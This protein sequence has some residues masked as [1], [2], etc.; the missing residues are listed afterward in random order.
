MQITL[1]NTLSNKREVFKPLDDSRVT[2]YVC[3][4]TVYG[5]AHLGNA[6]PAVVFDILF[7]L[8]SR[9]YPKVE[10]ARNITD[11]D[12]KIITAAAENKEP[13]A[14]LTE[15]WRARYE[16]E[17]N[18][19]GVLPPTHAPLATQYINEIITL[20][21]KLIAKGNAYA[22]HGHVFF[23]TP[24]FADY[25]ALSNRKGDAPAVARV[26]AQPFKQDPTDFVLWKPST[27]EMPGWQSPWGRGR[28]G[29]HIECSAMAAAC[30]GETI[31]IHGGGQDLIFPH[32]ENEIAQSRCAS[33]EKVFANYWLH[34]G[35]LALAG[36][37]M[38]KSLG[39]DLS[40]GNALKEHAGE[41]VRYALLATHYRHPLN[42]S[43]FVLEESK[44]ALDSLYRAKE[45]LTA[46]G[47][48]S[49]AAAD[50]PPPEVIN[51]LCDDLNTPAAFAAL[52][53]AAGAV[54]KGKADDNQKRAFLSGAQ[55]L[56]LLSHSAEQWFKGGMQKQTNESEI[57]KL[58]TARNNARDNRD[59]AAADKIRDD[60]LARGIV[61]E[62]TPSGTKWR[63]AS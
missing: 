27:P 41:T 49:E 5:A 14:A 10:Y 6:R 22:T 63:A 61:L 46:E 15:R 54:N 43:G 55:L 44:H 57:E 11:I 59:F 35:H 26:D 45:K 48:T 25:G 2:M 36:E 18:L 12:D 60:L 50:A 7:R 3:G 51:A 4:P 21:E 39:N 32:H 40:L 8:L 17:M 24:T 47:C 16:E 53:T 52:H 42:W 20:A 34:N 33:G 19:L 9:A 29:W 30:L 37:K 62:D 58:I 31:D 1:H 23:A 28:P 38:S 13:V 56:G